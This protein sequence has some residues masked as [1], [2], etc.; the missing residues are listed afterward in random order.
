M[1]ATRRSLVL[2]VAFAATAAAVTVGEAARPALARPAAHGRVA[3]KPSQLVAAKA[4][5]SP[6]TKKARRSRERR[7]EPQRHGRS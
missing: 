1:V 2:L 7:F 3:E 4:S 5:P 6:H